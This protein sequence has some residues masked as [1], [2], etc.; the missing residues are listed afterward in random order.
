MEIHYRDID[1]TGF[2]TLRIKGDCDLYSAHGLTIAAQERLAKGVRRLR[3]D[4]AGVE[5]L[6]STGVGVIIRLVQAAKAAGRELRFSGIRGTPRR[7]LVMC[8]VISLL[9]ED[10][11]AGAAP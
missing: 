1:D 7:V 3:I 5:Y 10:V 4:L 8:N 9:K 2:E 6:D 11:L